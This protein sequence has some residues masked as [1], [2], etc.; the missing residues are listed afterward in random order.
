MEKNLATIAERAFERWGDNWNFRAY[1]RKNVEPAM[2]DAT[3]HR[4]NDSVSAQIDCTT[5][6]NCC[7]E[8]HPH[9]I[10]S[11]V[12][13]LAQHLQI[14]DAALA[15]KHLSPD[16]YGEHV[17]NRK[18]CPMLC[19]NRCTVYEA[20]PTD[21]RGYPHLHQ[22]DFLARS[23]MVIENYRVCPIIF[24]VYEALKE[25]FAYDPAVD[26]IGDEEQEP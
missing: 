1:L 22:P 3:V 6:G 17:F 21:C 2:L 15:E 8:V 9:L 10:P 4:L 16:E 18:P 11:D 12:T 14:P 20:R 7:R 25:E 13:R 23:I 5:C 24:N 19:G 26:Y